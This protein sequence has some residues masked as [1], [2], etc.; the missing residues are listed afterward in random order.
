MAESDNIVITS[1]SDKNF[2]DPASP[3]LIKLYGNNFAIG[4]SLSDLYLIGLLN[5][6]PSFV[7]NMSYT[8]AKIL[9]QNINSYLE[10]F[11]SSGIRIPTVEEIRDASSK[12]KNK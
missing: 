7:V 5:G 1:P 9:Q 11:E 6:Q 4:G 8:A 12:N 3:H 2:I 10:K